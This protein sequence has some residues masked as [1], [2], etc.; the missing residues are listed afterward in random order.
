MLKELPERVTYA[1]RKLINLVETRKLREFCIK[2]N[3]TH[4]TIYKLAVTDRLPTYK[5]MSSLVNVIS[6][7]EWL[8]YE[9]ERLPYEPELL[10]G[11]STDKVCYYVKKHENEYSLISK[12]YGLDIS[13]SY[14]LLVTKS[15]YP[16]IKFMRNVCAD[17]NPIEFFVEDIDGK[18]S[19]EKFILKRGDVAINGTDYVLV[20]TDEKFFKKHKAYIG[21]E[22]SDSETAF[23]IKINSDAGNFANPYKLS[24]IKDGDNA[25]SVGQVNDK[26]FENVSKALSVLSV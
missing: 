25:Y 1:Q 21:C 3:V 6:P 19:K 13:S 8:F 10:P 24:I 9:D 7:I 23:S 15:M 4:T 5:I 12:K 11:W 22:V 14:R 16:P 17:T 20:L 2:W 26:A 18:E